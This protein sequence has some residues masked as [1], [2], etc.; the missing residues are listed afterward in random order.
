MESAKDALVGHELAISLGVGTERM[1][2]QTTACR[3]RIRRKDCVGCAA[4]PAV[5]HTLALNM[6]ALELVLDESLCDNCSMC[7]H[8]CPVGAL[9]LE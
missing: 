3:L 9:Y 1:K 2:E 6:D 4:C 5:C 8:V 7:I